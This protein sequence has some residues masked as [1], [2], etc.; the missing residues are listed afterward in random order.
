MEIDYQLKDIQKIIGEAQCFGTTTNPI[1]GIASLTEANAYDLSFLAN[2]K[3]KNGVK[4]TQAAVVLL[5]KNYEGVPKNNQVYLKVDN[6]SLSLAKICDEIERQLWP[7]KPP[8]IHP[9]AYVDKTAFIAKTAFIGPFCFVGKN[10][11]VGENAI[12]ESHVFVGD[13]VKI[14]DNSWIKPHVSILDYCAIGKRVRIDPNAVIGSDGF[15]YETVKGTHLR[16]PQVGNVVIED[17]VNIG[18]CTTIDRARFKETRIGEGTKIDNLVQIA[19][20]VIIGKNCLIV[21]QTGIS[22]ST[23]LEDNVI[24]AGQVGLVGH[25]RIHKGAIIGAQSGINNDVEAGAYIRGTPAYPINEAM[26][27]DI[28]KKRLPELFKR[29]TTLEEQVQSANSTCRQ[30]T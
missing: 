19:H 12:L 5:P 6:P 14:G 27:I 4:D 18:A 30:E 11:T 8:Q 25:I 28:Y 13:M 23:V 7:S 15:G 20:N 9:T 17:D 10:S 24:L 1:K 2:P 3:Y 21:A 29:V 16:V 26:R 22:G